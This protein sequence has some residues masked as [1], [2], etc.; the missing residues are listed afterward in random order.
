ML[1]V[2]KH[3]GDQIMI[4]IAKK[5]ISMKE[6]MKEINKNKKNLE[7]SIKETEA[8][9]AEIFINNGISNV[10]VDNKNVILIEKKSITC[11]QSQGLVNFLEEHG[12]D[13]VFNKPINNQS[14]G[15]M[16]RENPEM[17]DELGEHIEI[18]DYYQ[19]Q[20]RKK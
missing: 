11:D 18:T 7:E 20:V 6:E 10:G 17:I 3:I 5:L 12:F 13:E 14:F 16:L 8:E 19:F 4:E 2:W 15:K 1:L 9:L